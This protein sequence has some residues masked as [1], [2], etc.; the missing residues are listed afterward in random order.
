M[1]PLEWVLLPGEELSLR[2]FELRY[3]TLVGELMRSTD[4]TFGVVLIARGREVGGGEQRCDVGALATI[5]QCSDLGSGRYLLRCQVGDRIRVQE[6]LP[7]DPYPRATAEVW[8]DDP[9]NPLSDR[10]FRDVEGRIVA[11][12]QRIAEARGTRFVPGRSAVLGV[13]RR[14]LAALPPGRR[15]YAL[16]ARVPM[17]EA[18]RYAVLSA[19]SLTD[20]LKALHEAVDT[21]AAMVEFQL[22][23]GGSPPRGH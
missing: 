2:I 1:F 6:W 8:P 17:G 4:P 16:A 11:L 14:K 13:R 22:S 20:R 12:L 7:D 3:T 18:D 19:A 10:Q 21:V 9:G 5:T 15:L 23:S